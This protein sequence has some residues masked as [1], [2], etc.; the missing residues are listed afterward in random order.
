MTTMEKKERLK[1]FEDK[2]NEFLMKKEAK[3]V[4]ERKK[5]DRRTVK[6]AIAKTANQQKI[7]NKARNWELIWKLVLTFRN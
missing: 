4:K 3:L 1:Q 6:R 5:K 7:I 2:E